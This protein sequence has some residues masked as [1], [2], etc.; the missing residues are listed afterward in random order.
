[1]GRGTPLPLCSACWGRIKDQGGH[2]HSR[3]HLLRGHLSTGPEAGGEHT[4][5]LRRMGVY[6]SLCLPTGSVV[7]GQTPLGLDVPI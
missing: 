2:T 1:M 6:F 3:E 7:F 4:P 5:Q